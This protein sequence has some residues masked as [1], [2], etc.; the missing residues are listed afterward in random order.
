[1]VKHHGWEQLVLIVVLFII[2]SFV[3]GGAGGPLTG[4]LFLGAQL[5]GLLG[6]SN[7]AGIEVAALNLVSL[8]F[9]FLINLII[10]YVISTVLIFVFNLFGGKR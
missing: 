9:V 5:F 7:V 3:F 10:Y 8:I 4:S 2:A 1:M 6:S